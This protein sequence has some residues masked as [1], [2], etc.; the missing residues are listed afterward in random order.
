MT[1]WGSKEQTGP[2]TQAAALSPGGALRAGLG[3]PG[4]V[5]KQPQA[6]QLHLEA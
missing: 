2:L 1:A 4:S 3:F 5:G 6:V